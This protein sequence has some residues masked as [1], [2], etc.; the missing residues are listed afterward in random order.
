MKKREENGYENPL[1]IL[2]RIKKERALPPINKS[3][4]KS[5]SSG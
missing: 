5:S 1:D 2:K 4:C 3:L